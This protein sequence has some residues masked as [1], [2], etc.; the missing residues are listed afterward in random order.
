MTERQLFDA[1]GHV[2]D[3]LILQA[4]APQRRKPAVYWRPLVSIAACACLAIGMVG[5]GSKMFRCGSSAPAEA[6]MLE[7][8]NLES[9]YGAADSSAP[10]ETAMPEDRSLES[11][12]GADGGEDRVCA[13][14][15]ATR[16]AVRIDGV[17]YYDTGTVSD[18]EY[19]CGT[20]DGV[21]SDTTDADALPTEDGQSNF[22]TGYGYQFA[23]DGTVE[24]EIDGEYV[25]FAAE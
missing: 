7:D 16:R 22:G 13:A 14:A 25:I 4:D 23:A 6:A 19:R 10:T 1:I 12:Y 24:V 11:T 9:T 15:S 20:P 17:L 3:D 8:R 18:M 21:I 5:F 2:D